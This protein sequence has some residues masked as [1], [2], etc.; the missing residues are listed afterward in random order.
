MNAKRLGWLLGS[1]LM[2]AVFVGS[3][4]E[5]DLSSAVQDGWDWTARQDGWDWTKVQQA[6]DWTKV[7]HAWDWTMIQAGWDWT[8]TP[9]PVTAG[10]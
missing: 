4:L 9:E 1:V 10:S 7:Q 8:A 5:A 3:V 6:W 2:L